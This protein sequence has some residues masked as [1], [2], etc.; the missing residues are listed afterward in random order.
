MFKSSEPIGDVS[1]LGALIE[2]E[3]EKERLFKH[4]AEVRL[5]DVETFNASIF[6]D[7]KTM[8][9][10][11]EG[12]EA[13]TRADVLMVIK[14]IE[15]IGLVNKEM[16]STAAE[17]FSKRNH[18]VIPPIFN[19]VANKFFLAC[20]AL[21]EDCG[22]G[23]WGEESCKNFA[24]I[25]DA[26]PI[27]SSFFQD[28]L[29]EI[30]EKDNVTAGPWLEKYQPHM[31]AQDCASSLQW[32]IEE[33]NVEAA[34]FELKDDSSIRPI[35]TNSAWLELAGLDI[36]T[37]PGALVLDVLAQLDLVRHKAGKGNR[38]SIEVK[39]DS[40]DLQIKISARHDE[41]S[42][43]RGRDTIATKIF[44]YKLAKF[45]DASSPEKEAE[46]LVEQQAAK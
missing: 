46:K 31:E 40:E 25:R 1:D 28:V 34:R 18:K 36:K 15:A 38:A 5:E 41:S 10:K 43:F 35:V 23:E 14:E 16:Y 32:L 2:K 37:K 7:T 12:G 42:L 17:I 44:K 8:A 13:P 20:D 6:P 21:K 26:W 39:R 29:V 33:L 9:H 19:E 22:R 11:W 27:Y 24:T 4:T 45:A 30:L 3:A